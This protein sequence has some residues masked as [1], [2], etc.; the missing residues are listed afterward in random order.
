MKLILKGVVVGSEFKDSEVFEIDGQS[1]TVDPHWQIAVQGN[2]MF[3]PVK[4]RDFTETFSDLA[5][6]DSFE[7]EVEVKGSGIK[8]DIK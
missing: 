8:F 6:G 7:S 2:N 5:L 3:Y 4:V 1:F